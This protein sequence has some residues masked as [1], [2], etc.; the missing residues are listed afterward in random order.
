MAPIIDSIPSLSVVF[1]ESTGQ[2]PPSTEQQLA[3]TKELLEKLLTRDRGT[4]THGMEQDVEILIKSSQR[5]IRLMRV[6][7]ANRD[8]MKYLNI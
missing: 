7:G 3:K 1:S 6:A 2:S 5:H 4:M 8:R